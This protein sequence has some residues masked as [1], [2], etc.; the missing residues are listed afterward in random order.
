MV[1]DYIDS[2]SAIWKQEKLEEFFLPMDVEVIKGIPLSTRNQVDFW[3]WHF[4]RTGI[5]FSSFGVQ[6]PSD[7]EED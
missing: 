7:H 4:E 5:F 3:A 1:T 2:T 6:N